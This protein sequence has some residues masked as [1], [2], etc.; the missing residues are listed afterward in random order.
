MEEKYCPGLE[1]RTFVFN[2]KK[3]R[4]TTDDTY[5]PKSQCICRKGSFAELYPN[6]MTGH[7]IGV[8]RIGI[9]CLSSFLDSCSD[10]ER[11][12]NLQI[13]QPPILKGVIN[14]DSATRQWSGTPFPKQICS[15]SLEYSRSS[16]SIW[17]RLLSIGESPKSL[18]STG[19]SMPL[20]PLSSI[21]ACLFSDGLFSAVQ[22]RASKYT[23]RLISSLRSQY[24]TESP[25]PMSVTTRLWTG[26]TTNPT[27]AIYLT[28]G[29]ST[30]Q[31]SSEYISAE[32]SSSFGR[33]GNLHSRLLTVTKC[34]T[35]RMVYSSTR[36]SDLPGNTMQG[37][38]LQNCE[39]L[40]IMPKTLDVPLCTTPT[41]S[42]LPLKTSHCFIVVAGRSSFFSSGSSSI[43]VSSV[44]G[45]TARM[46]CVYRFTSQ[47]S[48]TVLS[49]LLST[50]SS[51]E[52]LSSKLCAYWAAPCWSRMTS[53][54]FSDSGRTIWSIVDNWN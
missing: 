37:T 44:S 20:I 2:K 16:R 6:S 52:D 21:S 19:G 33:K 51:W 54:N 32:H 8:F 41:T 45:V 11:S 40:S 42:T 18:N 30:S 24:S 22:S 5:S 29:I 53:W 46:P 34:L 10:A 50:T 17:Y 35:G 48:P 39:G 15:E 28:V 49:P 27:P 31:D 7:K 4:C 12:E 43:S 13:S 9:T 1:F 14:L 47:L 25:T 23:H 38:T 26:L 36:Q 3:Q